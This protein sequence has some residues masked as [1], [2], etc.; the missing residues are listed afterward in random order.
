MPKYKKLITNILVLILIFTSY[1]YIR[2]FQ[3]D[4]NVR[5]NSFPKSQI[6]LEHFLRNSES[7]L[8]NFMI[9]GSDSP[10]QDKLKMELNQE[11]GNQDDF[12]IE[13]YSD[14]LIYEYNVSVQK[15]IREID[16]ALN[17]FGNEQFPSN[18]KNLEILE[19]FRKNISKCHI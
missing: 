4:R 2:D 13:S 5:I 6:L 8:I 14:D 1:Q 11:I 15:L 10:V 9:D 7:Y 19:D 17:Y 18:H 3:A 12:L 16:I